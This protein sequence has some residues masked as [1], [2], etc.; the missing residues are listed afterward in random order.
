MIRTCLSAIAVGLFAFA[1]NTQDTAPAGDT[2]SEQG[3]ERQDGVV[4]LE[5]FRTRRGLSPSRREDGEPA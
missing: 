1:A 5:A 4:S 3:A 2:A